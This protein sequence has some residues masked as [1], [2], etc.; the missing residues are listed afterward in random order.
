MSGLLSYDSKL[1]KVLETIK[2]LMILGILSMVCCLPIVTIGSSLTALSDVALKLARGEEGYITKDFFRSFKKNFKPATTIW[3]LMMALLIFFL[4]DIYIIRHSLVDFPDFM[5]IVIVVALAV[6]LLVMTYIF[7]MIARFENTL[8]G[9]LKNG[10]MM[11]LLN[12]P[13]AILMLVL[14]ALPSVIGGYFYEIIP[15]VLMCGLSVPAWLSAK[16]IYGKYFLGMEEKIQA[17]EG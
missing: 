3:M 13:K 12:L 9:Y 10:I 5:M 11:T 6:V 4:M 1:N 16:L 8:K 14:Y 7:P 2:N 15:L 17:M